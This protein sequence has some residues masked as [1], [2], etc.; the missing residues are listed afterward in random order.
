MGNACDN[1]QLVKNLN[2]RNTDGDR[3]GNVCDA[4]LNNDLF[5]NAIDLTIF[6]TRFGTSNADADFNGD[7]FVNSIDPRNPHQSLRQGART[8]GLV[9]R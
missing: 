1:C 6:K 3:F 9:K 2:Q 5:T 4:D 8:F 7:G